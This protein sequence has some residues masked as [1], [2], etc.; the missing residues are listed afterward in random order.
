[1]G[2]SPNHL[3]EDFDAQIAIG[4]DVTTIALAAATLPFVWVTLGALVS[5]ALLELGSHWAEPFMITTAV[6]SALL[7]HLV[8][9]A[10]VGLVRQGVPLAIVVPRW[11]LN[12]VL[13]LAVLRVRVLGV[14]ED[15]SDWW[16]S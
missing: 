15:V 12:L 1:M 9:R 3:P 7:L 8:T 14:V 16:D 6:V 13:S 2:E 10:I 4:R 11:V 5:A